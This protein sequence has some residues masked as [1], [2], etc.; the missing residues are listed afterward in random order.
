MSQKDN[1]E[2]FEE[3]NDFEL[4]AKAHTGDVIRRAETLF[5]EREKA[6]GFSIRCGIKQT[7]YAGYASKSVENRRKMPVYAALKIAMATGASLDWLITGEGPKYKKQPG[8]Q[9]QSATTT[10]HSTATVAQGGSSIA[11]NRNPQT[12]EIVQIVGDDGFS[13]PVLAQLLQDPA[14]LDKCLEQL[15]TL[16]KLNF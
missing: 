5:L 15:Q 10:D 12:D 8:A 1:E 6:R 14:L 2:N 7:T 16:K 11:I 9:S 4:E 13:R 3:E